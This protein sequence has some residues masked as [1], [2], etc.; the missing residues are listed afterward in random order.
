M[1]FTV[2]ERNRLLTLILVM[3]SCVT[4]SVFAAIYELYNAA[5]DD[6]IEQLELSVHSQKELIAAVGRFDAKNS[7]TDHP[8]GALGGTLSQIVDAHLHYKLPG[9]SSEF[10]LIEQNNN[11]TSVIL[12][13]N[14]QETLIT[15]QYFLGGKHI[16]VPSWFSGVNSTINLAPLGS[17]HL[18]GILAVYD[19]VLISEH[20]FL[21]VSKVNEMEIRQPFIDAGLITLAIAILLILIGAIIITNQVN[22][23]INDLNNQLAFSRALLDTAINPIITVDS[24]G[25][26]LSFN[27]AT[28]AIFGYQKAQLTDQHISLLI[29]DFE[30]SENEENKGVCSDGK[31]LA[32]Q[33]SIGNTKIDDRIINIYIVADVTKRKQA[34]L[35]ARNT[36][37]RTEA[38]INAVQDGMI[39]TD[40]WGI[41]QSINPAIEKLFDYQ[42]SELVG[43]NVN[44]IIPNIEAQYALGKWVLSQGRKKDSSLF[45]IEGSV[46]NYYIDGK[47]Y[48]T[49][50]VR[51]ITERVAAEGELKRYREKL[52]EMVSSATA[53][54]NAIVQTAVHAVVSIDGKG[55]IHTFN[56]AAE[57]IFG[58]SAKEAVGRNVAILVP[59]MEDAAHDAFI[60]RYIDTG[61]ARI[62]GL[63]RE[64]E[65]IRKDGSKFPAH[66]AVGHS[67]LNN[68]EHL[69]VGY[70]SD[71]TEQKRTELE[72]IEAKDKAEEAV[73]VKSNFLA[74]M[75]HEIRTPM[76][77]VIGFSEILLQDNQLT[78]ENRQHIITIL[79]SGKNLLSIINDILDFSK[80]EAGGIELESICFHLSNAINDCLRTLELGANEKGLKLTC[81][82]SPELPK[83]VTGDPV[84]LRQVV[85]NLVGN[86]IK[87]TQQG[88]VK[89]K[90]E[91]SKKAGQV[92]FSISDSGIG[93]TQDELKKVF[94]PF[95]QADA[96]INRNFGGTGL[97][98]TISRQIV[99]L[100]GGQ[101]WAESKKDKG[102]VFYFTVQLKAAEKS[103][104]CL[105]GNNDYIQAD[106]SS[107][108]AFNI[109]LA[110]DI[111]TNATLAILRLEQQHHQVT[112]VE[113][114]Q[115]AL[116]E[117]ATGKYD[118]IL[119]DVQMPV[120]DGLT[121]TRLIRK[122]QDDTIKNIPIIALTA[123]VMMEDQV[124]CKNAG[125]DA[126]IA[127][128]IDFPK[129]FS[130]M[131]SVVHTSVG[132][133]ISQ[134]PSKVIGIQS[135]IDFSVLNNFVDYQKGIDTWVDQVVY[136]KAL[137]NFA[138]DYK[139]EA[140]DIEKILQYP[141][142]D[143][144]ICKAKIH[145][146]KGVSGN[147]FIDS[148]AKISEDIDLLLKEEEIEQAMIKVRDLGLLMSSAIDVILQLET[149]RELSEDKKQ[150]DLDRV[151]ELFK[152]IN[153]ALEELSPDAVQPH[154]DELLQ[155][156]NSK[157]I[158]AI[159]RA[160]DHFDFNVAKKEVLILA[161]NLNV[162]I[163]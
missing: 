55:I 6:H 54:I 116:S 50:V 156:L 32:L 22:P 59:D 5:Y 51:D 133:D 153:L 56:P 27:K 33:L 119:M 15:D 77:A 94:E 108:R 42:E 13:H 90:I 87:F 95:S 135:S 123:S 36:M 20:Q 62:V 78:K 28:L 75:S 100:M 91:T 7:Q 138:K 76:N 12:Q 8:G 81:E 147:L 92:L 96:S 110:E 121:A 29:P 73:K 60:Q 148:V 71:I 109:L 37:N 129:L 136:A 143:I 25:K 127:K 85:I 24:Q 114:G 11:L 57:K 93:M 49:G 120:M 125:M 157:D 163:E 141:S 4:L 31:E 23:M 113:N 145:A 68:N 161:E 140:K 46:S 103:A 38:I 17:L 65:A 9:K 52:E 19:H 107:P 117:A 105:F 151:K 66:L 84:R 150:M 21:L 154:M 131:E 106:Y 160:I 58:W 44:L 63:G 149:P 48:L 1:P 82:V 88:D 26:I 43:Q 18:N 34:E 130:T 111:Q 72:L 45:S 2:S 102:S 162:S 146:L 134:I 101:I 137:I 39:T 159:Q 86:A 158:A 10:I 41:I 89:V 30:E 69:F 124:L 67:A 83:L 139:N 115:K 98:T 35:L 128:P 152:Q 112:W 122:I 80:I 118:L 97:G 70:I 53:E 132:T 126:V 3:V 14:N 16:P 61:D 79:S 40:R 142:E 104:S 64:V 74:N 144:S 155:F 47:I 99:N